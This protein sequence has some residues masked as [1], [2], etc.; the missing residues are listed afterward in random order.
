MSQFGLSFDAFGNQ[1]T[2]WNNV[3]V[4]HVVIND[5]YLSNNSFL[6]VGTTMADISDHGNAA[7]V[8]S[9]AKDMLNLHESEMGH[10]TSACGICE[11]TGNLFKGKYAN[12]S[13]VCEP[14]SNLVHSDIL[15]PAGATFTAKRAE[16]EKEFLA[17]TDSWFRPVNSTVG[18]DGA[19][20]IVDFYRKLVEHPDWLAMA[21]STGFYT[22]AGKIKESDFL[23][24]NDR[25]RVYRIV[26]KDYKSDKEENAGIE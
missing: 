5:K 23:E 19:L 8:Y 2:D 18:P 4:R 9:I 11:Y 17:S 12:A 1:F 21:D 13:F 3:H 7:P 10:F 14:V 20:Y 26:P 24:G 25:G 16:E 6:S 15:S 22:H